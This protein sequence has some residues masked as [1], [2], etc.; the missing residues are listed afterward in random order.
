MA[1]KNVF[2]AVLL[3][4][5]P[6]QTHSNIQYKTFLFLTYNHIKRDY[7]KHNLVQLISSQQDVIHN[8]Q[9]YSAHRREVSLERKW[10]NKN[11]F[12]TSF[13]KQAP[14]FLVRVLFLLIIMVN[15]CGIHLTSVIGKCHK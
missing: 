8:Q 12:V 1:Y 15:L 3:T 2:M 5:W 14:H 11:K 13:K 7:N 9:I 10:Q 4:S 6:R